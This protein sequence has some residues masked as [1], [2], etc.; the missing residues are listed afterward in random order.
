MTN[1]PKNHHYVAQM[2]AGRFTD[3]DGMLWAYTKK[4]GKLFRG[5]PKAVFAETH[6]YTIEGP[7]GK[8]DTSF[9]AALSVL[10]GKANT[11]IGK[12][13]DGAR[14]GGPIALTADERE[15]W[16]RYL[17]V[18]WK[19]VPDVHHKYATSQ[20]QED[21]LDQIF[22][23]FRAQGGDAA[24]Q[25]AA[26]DNP[27]ERKRILQGGKVKAL[28]RD[29]GSVR[30]ALATRGVV[31]LRITAPNQSFAIG[32]L[33]IVR[34]RGDLLA[35]DAEVWL[36]VAS[37]VAVGIGGSPGGVSSVSIDDTAAIHTM[38]R[39]TAGQSTTFAAGS[40]VLVET[41]RDEILSHFSSV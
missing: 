31:V 32:S 10:E 19:R 13:V 24:A 15:T 8:K 33:P 26:L 4:T 17:Y 22:D 40:K 21:R 11:V 28:E 12:L 38:N 39:V 37:D 36:P 27:V 5:P 7:D 34:T 1:I 6:L 35:A 16:D 9:E 3:A 41:L 18:Q 14:A 23:H 20:E 30:A 29:P 25:V 2:H